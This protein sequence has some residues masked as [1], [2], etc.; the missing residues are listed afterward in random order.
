M[1]KHAAFV[2][3]ISIL[4]NYTL[5][6]FSIDCSIY[7]DNEDS[8]RICRIFQN[9]TISSTYSSIWMANNHDETNKIDICD[10]DSSQTYIKCDYVFNFDTSVTDKRL[11]SID[12]SFD[13]G[14]L[15]LDPP[16]NYPWPRF[17]Q[18]I[19]LSGS[20]NLEGTW[21]N[22]SSLPNI[23]YHLDLSD[24]SNLIGHLDFSSLPRELDTLIYDYTKLYPY[25]NDLSQ[26]PPNLTY[27]SA[28]S[29][30]TFSSDNTFDWDNLPKDLAYLDIND[31]G[32]TGTVNLTNLPNSLYYVD[33]GYNDFDS[34][35]MPIAESRN[36]HDSLGMS[37]VD[38]FRIMLNFCFGFFFLIFIIRYMYTIHN[39]N[40]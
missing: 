16:T 20:S 23:V 18:Y 31:I 22:F 15:H 38:I 35:V 1:E 8:F 34:I 37:R 39:V 24:M 10:W 40:L 21:H 26:L 28:Q 2:A 29:S 5:L 36:V 19:D 9:A 11:I 14:I 32:L 12:L 6:S 4:V 17:L 7:I 30:V 33:G 3:L 25:Y 13:G 27:W